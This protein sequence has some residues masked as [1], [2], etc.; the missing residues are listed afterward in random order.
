MRFYG[1][2]FEL[3]KL[4]A[5]GLV[6]GT[7]LLHLLHSRA[8]LAATRTLESLIATL[9]RT[10]LDLFTCRAQIAL[11]RLFNEKK[12]HV[13]S[14]LLESPAELATLG[15]LGHT[16]H[17]TAKRLDKPNLTPLLASRSFHRRRSGSR[18]WSCD[19]RIGHGSSSPLTTTLHLVNL[20]G[21]LEG[22]N[23]ELDHDAW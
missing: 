2:Q 17:A 14:L 8:A 5:F 3:K 7:R 15:R 11:G 23:G 10:L 21:P 18:D 13:L 20:L 19:R 4:T 1:I 16:R 6:D 12:G 9:D 22:S